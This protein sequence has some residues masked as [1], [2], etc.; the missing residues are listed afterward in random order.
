MT[1]SK[2]TIGPKSGLNAEQIMSLFQSNALDVS[3]H[4]LFRVGDV[5]VLVRSTIAHTPWSVVRLISRRRI[6]AT[7]EVRREMV[8]KVITF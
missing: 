1:G 5:M 6:Q 8:P 7:S 4:S 2:R 3:K